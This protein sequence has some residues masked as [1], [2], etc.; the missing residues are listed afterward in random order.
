MMSWDEESMED[1]SMEWTDGM[2]SSKDLPYFRLEWTDGVSTN[3]Q[4]S[5]R[6]VLILQTEMDRWNIY[7]LAVSHTSEDEAFYAF[8]SGTEEGGLVPNPPTGKTEE[9]HPKNN[10]S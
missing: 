8:S 3:G 5:S 9:D 1:K 6:G 7:K 10:K 2:L 4:L